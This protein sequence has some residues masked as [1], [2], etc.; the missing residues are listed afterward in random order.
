[1]SAGCQVTIL[2]MDSMQEILTKNL[3]RQNGESQVSEREGERERE[4]ERE[5]EGK[6]E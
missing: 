5:K 2:M 6:E 3:T 1:M 4:R